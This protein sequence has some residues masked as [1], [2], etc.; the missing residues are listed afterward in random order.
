MKRRGGNNKNRYL[1][2]GRWALPLTVLPCM[3][4]QMQSC[5]GIILVPARSRDLT[6][7]P[8]DA[9]MTHPPL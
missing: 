8:H 5:I 9:H 6:I 2:N 3:V 7:T 4:E 1:D